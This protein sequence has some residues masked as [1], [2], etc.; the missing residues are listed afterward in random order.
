M[1]FRREAPRSAGGKRGEIAVEAAGKWA[2]YFIFEGI[3]RNVI[4]PT[5]KKI[6]VD[7]PGELC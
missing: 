3:I 4:E 2:K 7:L 1:D 6:F 5:E